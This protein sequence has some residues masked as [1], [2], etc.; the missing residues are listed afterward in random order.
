MSSLTTALLTIIAN[1][2]TAINEVIALYNK[3]K[4]DMSESDQ[5]YIDAA[6]IKAQEDDAKA[7]ADADTALKAASER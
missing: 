1:A 5:A 6:L 3:I 7:T 4:G 2:P